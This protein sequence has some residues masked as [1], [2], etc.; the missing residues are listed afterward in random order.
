MIEVVG[1][2]D[3]V[4]SSSLL[5]AARSE[6]EAGCRALVLDLAEVSFC[7]A[8]GVGALTEIRRLAT[9]HGAVVRVARASDRVRRTA[10][11]VGAPDVVAGRTTR[12]WSATPGG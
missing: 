6:L 1:E 11:L 7:C 2:L 5:D 8:R 12:C 4:T 9:A 10:E 3:V